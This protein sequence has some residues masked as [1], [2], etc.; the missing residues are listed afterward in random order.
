MVAI[1]LFGVH[2]N[3]TAFLD[4]GI[5]ALSRSAENADNRGGV[6]SL[7]HTHF[8]RQTGR[9]SGVFAAS[10]FWGASRNQ[11]ARHTFCLLRVSFPPPSF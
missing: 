6:T 2:F 10:D 11:Q 9:F 8:F 1:P 5:V 4:V 3:G 7:L